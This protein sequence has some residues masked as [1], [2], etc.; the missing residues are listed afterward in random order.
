MIEVGKYRIFFG[1]FHGQWNSSREELALLVAGLWYHGYD[2]S[3]FQSPGMFKNLRDIITE[4]ELPVN[5]SDGKEYFYDWAHLTTA[6]VKGTPPGI[7]APMETVLEWFVSHSDWVIMA[8]PYE[9]MIDKLEPLWEKGLLSAV[10]LVNG[11]KAANRNTQLIAW[12][13]GLLKRGIKIP[14]VG[15]LD[16]HIPHG[17]QRPDLL[18]NSCYLPSQDI[19]I[20]GANRTGIIAGS[21]DI[22]DIKDALKKGMTF[23]EL[24][25]EREVI[26][27]PE[28]IEYLETNNYWS[29]VDENLE[30]HRNSS[31]ES[32]GMNLAESMKEF[33]FPQG[34]KSVRIGKGTA[35]AISGRCSIKI[36]ADFNRNTFYL[37]V[38]GK[39]KDFMSVNAVKVFHPLRVEVFSETEKGC[40]RT[41]ASISNVSREELEGLTFFISGNGQ[42]HRESL[43]Q[44]IPNA[45][46]EF[47]HE[48][49]ISE[50]TRPVKFEVDIGNGN[51]RKHISKDLVFVECPYIENPDDEKAWE[52]VL[53]VKMSGNCQEQMDV[54][55]STENAWSGD[56]DLSGEIRIGWNRNG[57]YFKLRITDDILVP[58]KTD[59]L[60]FGDCFQIGLNPVA[61]D[62]VGNQS[63]YDLMMTRGTEG[64][65]EKAFMERPL[66]MALEYPSSGRRLLDGLYR[67]RLNKEGQFDGVLMLP[68][69]LIEPMQPVKGYRFGLYY[70]LFDNDGAG[71]K[72]SLQWPLCSEKYLGQ[73][74]YVPYYGAWASVKLG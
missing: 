19:D 28:I 4:N 66:N 30:L 38:S 54:S 58:S 40:F 14:I 67:G 45:S 25:P 70:I 29:H 15:G 32:A 74:W 53:P 31:P 56:D 63:F 42:S 73:A 49:K 52:S 57:L 37:N 71:L 48:W 20:F 55:L 9:F 24:S 39:G 6:N 47:V 41:V 3:A 51:I 13:Q 5:V 72:T 61:T 36:P 50:P 11:Y 59:L 44:L 8:H 35:E 16:I 43:S 22:P 21:C 18:Y 10:E 33:I 1:D 26:G 7:D 23:V 2:F 64:D 12:Y 34:I 27:D 60:M 17:R 62:A 68:F 46:I 65:K 69:H